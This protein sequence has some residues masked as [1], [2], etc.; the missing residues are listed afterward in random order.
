MSSRQSSLRP[1]RKSVPL[2]A[3]ARL[4]VQ[5]W[6]VCGEI[7]SLQ[8]REYGGN[9]SCVEVRIADQRIIFDA[10]TGLSVLGQALTHHAEPSVSFNGHIFLSLSQW[11]RTQGL[12]F[13]QPAFDPHN[14][15]SVYGPVAI[16]GASIK[17]QLMDQMR[18][19]LSAISLRE[20]R[21]ILAF[22]DVAP[23]TCISLP[24]QTDLNQTTPLVQPGAIQVEAHMI[25]P[26]I[27]AMGYRLSWRGLKVVYGTAFDLNDERSVQSLLHLS[28]SADLLIFGAADVSRHLRSPLHPA[29]VEAEYLQL[30]ERLKPTG[31]R[32]V[33][34]T[35]HPPLC[36]DQQLQAL[37]TLL[38][39]QNPRVSLARENTVIQLHP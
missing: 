9:T 28:Q 22:H 20:M 10:G 2:P 39:Q 17:H 4:S 26:Q 29:M 8:S 33:L 7:P 5:C 1:H 37:E 24:V 11:G 18:L 21:A 30:L 23:A 35:R 34:I 25:N 12:S 3:Q 32:Q 19:P 36:A 38:H 13:F 27:Q 16:T 15:L 6:G 14:R 31:V